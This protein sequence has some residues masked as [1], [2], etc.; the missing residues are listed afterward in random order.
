[1]IK[2][3]YL[4]ESPYHPGKYTIK[5]N[6][7]KLPLKYTEGSY[8]VLFARLMGLTYPSFLRMCRDLFD[9]EILGK[10]SMYPVAY[11]QKTGAEKVLFDILN[12][13]VEIIMKYKK[14]IPNTFKEEF[15][16][17]Y[18]RFFESVPD[19]SFFKELIEEYERNEEN[20]EVW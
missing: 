9:A 11:F 10:N 17:E 13:R 14:G 12:R 1:M 19:D 6:F 3:F 20:R 8:N 5:I 2:Y 7:D 18:E 4:E 15:I 16:K